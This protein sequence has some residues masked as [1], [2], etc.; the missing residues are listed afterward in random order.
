MENWSCPFL[1]AHRWGDGDTPRNCTP[2]CTPP[3]PETLQRNGETFEICLFFLAQFGVNSRSSK[4]SKI[5]I[6]SSFS[7][8]WPRGLASHNVTHHISRGMRCRL[9]TYPTDMIPIISIYMQV[10]SSVILN[11]GCILNRRR[12]YSWHRLVSTSWT[13]IHIFPWFSVVAPTL[14]AA[15][16]RNAPL[17]YDVSKLCLGNKIKSQIGSQKLTQ[18]AIPHGTCKYGYRRR[19]IQMRFPR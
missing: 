4:I 13:V 14:N 11:E 7:V 19:K 12:V 9:L 2:L 6:V 1:V 18:K 8:T 5:Q 16:I 15:P 3:E 10:P 17:I